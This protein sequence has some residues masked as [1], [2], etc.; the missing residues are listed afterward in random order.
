MGFIECNTL[1]T[2]HSI[3]FFLNF[4]QSWFDFI[5]EYKIG[6]F[7]SDGQVLLSWS[8]DK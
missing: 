2:V 3:R 5:I 7:T 8:E 4:T 1:P 6:T